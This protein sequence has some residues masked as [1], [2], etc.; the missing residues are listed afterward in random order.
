MANG[1]IVNGLKNSQ[2]SPKGDKGKKH[3]F[4]AKKYQNFNAKN[5]EKARKFLAKKIS[6]KFSATRKHMIFTE[7]KK[8][9][10]KKRSVPE[11][12]I[13]ALMRYSAVLG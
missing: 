6:K 12:N 10:V 3:G 11:P 13:R 8:Q 4:L 2:I 5:A 9:I 7:R 1:K